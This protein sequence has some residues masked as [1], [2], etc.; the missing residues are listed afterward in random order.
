[1]ATPR[2]NIKV[3]TPPAGF[4]YQA[5]L[6]TR[7]EETALIDEIRLLPLKEF[8]FHGYL[9]KRRT[10]SFGWRYDF[11]GASLNEADPLPEFVLPLR[12]R[13]AEFAGL[14]P[15]KLVH[16]LFTEYS[17]GTPIGWH[18]DKSVFGDVIG[19]SL[20]S[21]CTFRFRR[22]TA[23]GWERYTYEPKPRSGY[24]LRGPARTDWEHSIPPVA[25]LRYS[26][27]FR[28][29]KGDEGEFVDHPATLF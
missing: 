27:A 18:R 6:V 8:E 14:A 16:A 9:G 23:A 29:L 28:T 26:I 19:I 22:S 2:K 13:A 24:L 4:K 20:L 21:P 17:P 7:D 1:M 12:A 11:A 25:E 3:P 15:E 5:E 10:A